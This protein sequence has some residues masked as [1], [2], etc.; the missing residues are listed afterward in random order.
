MIDDTESLAELMREMVD[1]EAW[2]CVEGYIKDRIE[3]HKKQLM[4]CQ[5]EDVIKHR[6]KVEAYGSVLLHVQ[7]MM[8]AGQS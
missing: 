8:A 5:I 3:D 6:A 7:H 1:S 4:T 2:Q